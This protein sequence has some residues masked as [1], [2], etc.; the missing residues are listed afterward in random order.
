MSETHAQNS[1]DASSDPAS[2]AGP[3]GADGAPAGN[4][5][6]PSEPAKKR[7]G[8]TISVIAAIAANIAVG[9]VK[10]IAA[11]ISGSSAMMSEGIHSIVDS[12]NGILILHGLH[13]A[14]R[15][16]TVEHPFGFGK[17]L[18]FWTLVVAVSIFAL[19]GGIS[20]MDGINAVKAAL[21]G[22]V[23]HGSMVMSFVVLLAA[24]AIEGSSLYV[25]L[26]QFNAARGDKGPLRYIHDCKDPSLYSVVLEDTAAE[27][28]LV[29]ALVGLILTTVTGNAVWDGVASIVIGLLLMSVS[30]VMLG[31]SKGLLV[32]EGMTRDELLVAR[33]LVEADPDVV[34]A[35]GVLTMYFG[36]DTMLVTVDVTFRE[37]IANEEVL[38]AIDRIEAALTAK[39]P[40]AKRIYIEAMNL[41][42]VERQLAKA[43]A[44]PDE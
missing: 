20:L 41:T 18:Y 6:Q 17:E 15:P 43:K 30:F 10:F 36:P 38:A 27:C 42:G 3:A 19:G 23:E 9:I 44:M 8:G 40:Q 34:K 31:E 26:R 5:A 22:N 37:G 39:F 11:G 2:P 24:M 29:F 28:G 21:A 7:S 4:A 35:G 25:G 12:G 33:T 14:K 32:G 1:P 13:R 16:A